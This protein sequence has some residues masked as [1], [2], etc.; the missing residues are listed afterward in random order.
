MPF[1]PRKSHIFSAIFAENVEITLLISLLL[2]KVFGTRITYH[3]VG[4]RQR[5]D[6]Q[7]F[8]V[9]LARMVWD[10]PQTNR[11]AKRGTDY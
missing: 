4:C 1:G 5:K 10:L 11:A 2:G 7:V 9:G 8:L 3:R 6:G